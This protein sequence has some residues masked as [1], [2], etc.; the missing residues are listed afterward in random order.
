MLNHL[1]DNEANSTG[2]TLIYCLPEFENN[3]LFS[4]HSVHR[5]LALMVPFVLISC[6][7][8]QNVDVVQ[9]V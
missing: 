6:I 5:R 2:L 8:V 4:V 3:L 1:F 9:F 7:I